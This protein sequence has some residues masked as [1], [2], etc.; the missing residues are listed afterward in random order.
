[1]LPTVKTL[2]S[3]GYKLYASMGTAD[4]YSEH[5]IQVSKLGG[6]IDLNV[7]QSGGVVVCVLVR[8]LKMTLKHI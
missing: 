7:I 1:M 6:S 8:M 2:E 5:G 3:M 4:F